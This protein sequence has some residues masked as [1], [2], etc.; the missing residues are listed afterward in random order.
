LAHPVE[1]GNRAL[2]TLRGDEEKSAKK[3][4]AEDGKFT[5]YYQIFIEKDI[6]GC[7]LKIINY[8]QS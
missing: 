1:P 4:V 5:Y 6:N 2:R 7:F 8:N 3:A